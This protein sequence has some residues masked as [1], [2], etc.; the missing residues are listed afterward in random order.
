MYDLGGKFKLEGFDKIV[1]PQGR[2]CGGRSNKPMVT[3]R[4]PNGV[5][6]HLDINAAAMEAAGFK[7]GDKVD[8]YAKGTTFILE[9]S[10]AGVYRL[11]CPNKKGNVN[12]GRIGSVN[13]CTVIS[14]RCNGA[15]KF[16]ATA[17]N[18]MLFFEPAGE[19]E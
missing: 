4:R 17:V 11:R 15:S 7:D 18:G 2:G 3:I 13:L 1:V 10:F 9:K 16:N 5:A 8:L 14:S 19:E 12:T 6:R